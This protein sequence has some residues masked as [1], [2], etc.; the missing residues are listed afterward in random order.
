M[1]VTF[2][3]KAEGMIKVEIPDDKLPEL[4]ALLDEHDGLKQPIDPADLP[5][6]CGIDVQ[7]LPN[8]VA[9]EVDDVWW[10]GQKS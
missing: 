3:V 1:K 10:K 6:W 5:P 2:N 9:W 7:E 4:E 8:Q